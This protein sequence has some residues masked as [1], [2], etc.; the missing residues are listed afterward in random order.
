MEG[1]NLD[2]MTT[3]LAVH[4][5]QNKTTEFY[6]SKLW[7]IRRLQALGFSNSRIE[8]ILGLRLKPEHRGAD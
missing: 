6:H 2:P 5:D 4:I 3:V 8:G 1:E 7:S